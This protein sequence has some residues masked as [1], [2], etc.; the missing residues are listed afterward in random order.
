MSIISESK[1]VV[2]RKCNIHGDILQDHEKDCPRCDLCEH[3]VS[4]CG[5]CYK[6]NDFNWMTMPVTEDEFKLVYRHT[7]KGSPW[8]NSPYPR[9]YR[10]VSLIE[11]MLA[12]YAKLKGWEIPQ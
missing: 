1:E 9:Q 12:E 10:V 8:R 2:T 3:G 7:F 6:C 5:V 11:M 4:R